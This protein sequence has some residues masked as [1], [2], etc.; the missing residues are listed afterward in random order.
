MQQAMII[1]GE[2]FATTKTF[3]V[4][5]PARGEVF[6]QCPLADVAVLDAAVAAARR[7]FRGWADTP[8][9][10]R[11]AALNRIADALEADKETLATIL[12]TEQGKPRSGALGEIGAAIGWIRATAKL[13]P[14]V[15]VIQDDEKLSI[16]VHRKPLGVVGSITPW[17]HP[18]LIATWHIMPA[19]MAGNTVVVKPS[20]YTPLSTLRLVEIANAHL[21]RGVL[22]AVTGEGGLG[23]AI[24]GHTGIDKIVFTGSTP[25]GRN[26]MSNAANTLKRLTLE[27]GGNDAAIVLPDADIDAI[28]PVIFAKSF[29]NSGQT[30]AALKRLYVHDSIYDALSEKIATLA[31][32]AKVGPATD[33][34]SQYGP[35]QNKAQFDLVRDLADDARAHGGKFLAGGEPTDGAGYFFP[36]TVVTEVTDGMRVVDEEQ[37]GPILP[38]IRYTDVEDAIARA[39]A[40][41]NGLGGSI[42]SSDIKRAESLARRL[43]CGTAWVND[44]SAISPAAP[45]GGAKQSGLGVEF[46]HWGLEEYMQVQTVRIT[47]Q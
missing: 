5:D 6:A 13:R 23:R 35:L 17:N 11:A 9:D 22:N 16:E 38:I 21:P 12:S 39:N 2:K 14:P 33:P 8:I 45:F 19:L 18:V 29:G 46:G 37:F 27:L 1:D 4:I 3:D 42:W 43:E 41:E 15:E 10:D 20:S 28:A 36:L 34:A 25:T 7:A 31:R 24:T 26:I 40:N 30:C 44:H 47:K 32:A